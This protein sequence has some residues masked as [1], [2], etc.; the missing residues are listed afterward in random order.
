MTVFGCVSSKS[1][2]NR[3][4]C[5]GCLPGKNGRALRHKTGTG[6]HFDIR[7]NRGAVLYLTL[8]YMDVCS[9]GGAWSLSGWLLGCDGCSE[10]NGPG[11]VAAC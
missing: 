11:C 4:E 2:S 6:Q 10:T 8:L 9:I 7:N 3:S 1:S 5:I